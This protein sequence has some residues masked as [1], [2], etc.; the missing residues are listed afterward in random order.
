MADEWD[1]L[2]SNFDASFT[3]TSRA[4]TFAGLTN[5]LD[6][7]TLCSGGMTIEEY[8]AQLSLWAIMGSPLIL[9]N[10]F[11]NVDPKVKSPWPQK[12]AGY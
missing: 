7:M 12:A 3:L 10:N 2:L 4:L 8:K 6:M 5:H 9:G 1:V 11:S